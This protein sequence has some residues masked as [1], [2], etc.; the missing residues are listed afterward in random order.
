[1]TSDPYNYERRENGL[2]FVDDNDAVLDLTLLPEY[3]KNPLLSRIYGIV[4][5]TGIRASLEALLEERRPEAVLSETREGFDT[6]L[7]LRAHSSRWSRST[8]GRSTRKRRSANARPAGIARPSSTGD[9]KRPS[10]S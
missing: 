5:L 9:S 4:K 3:D 2:L 7:R 8:S 6:K 1:M 10:V